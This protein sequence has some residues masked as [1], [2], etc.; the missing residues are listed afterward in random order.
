MDLDALRSFVAFVDTGSFTRAA[1]QIHRTQ[2]AISMQMKKLEEDLGHSLFIK[3]GR[4]LLLTEKGKKLVSYARKIVSLHDEAVGEFSTL[5]NHRPLTIGCP[6]DYVD[7]VLADLLEIIHAQ[8]PTLHLKVL[9]DSSTKLRE[10]LDNGDIDLAIL[11]RAPDKEEGYI[12]RHDKGLWVHGG[13]PELVERETI[14][15][16]LYDEDCKFHTAAIDGLDKMGRLHDL[17]C[18]SSSSSTLKTLLKRGLGLGTLA[19]SSLTEGLYPL[20]NENMPPLPAVD[21]VLA[22]SPIPHPLFG[23]TQAVSLSSE[24]YAQDAKIA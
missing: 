12:L 17:I 5:Q 23:V 4:N 2:G 22:V 7:S 24:Y 9:C 1:K 10:Y 19:S 15:L 6:D 8:Y 14:P 18:T 16:V 11:T 20:A 3:E 13:F 21:I